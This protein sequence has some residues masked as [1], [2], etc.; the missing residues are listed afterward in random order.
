MK[1][2]SIAIANADGQE[3]MREGTHLIRTNLMSRGGQELGAGEKVQYRLHLYPSDLAIF[4]LVE[5]AGDASVYVWEPRNGLHPDHESVSTEVNFAGVTIDLAGFFA[6]ENSMYVVEVHGHEPGT[7]YRL[8]PAGDVESTQAV[9]AV[10]SSED[11][12][13]MDERSLAAAEVDQIAAYEDALRGGTT[14]Q[15]LA[16]TDRGVQL[17]AQMRP[18]HPD[19]LSTPWLAIEPPE[20]PTNP[21]Q[22]GAEG[23]PVYLPLVVR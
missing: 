14:A 12:A 11:G 8:V 13:T 4:N 19:T 2:L 6:Q 9:T 7:S 3:S 18:D 21:P 23:K 10:V 22:P 20:E 5:F 16:A 17:A 1:Y 15:E